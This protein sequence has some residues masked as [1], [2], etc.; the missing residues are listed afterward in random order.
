MQLLLQSFITPRGLLNKYNNRDLKVALTDTEKS[1]LEKLPKMTEFTI[2]LCY[3]ILRFEHLVPEPSSQWE[4]LPDED[5]REITDDIKRIVFDTNDV[6]NKLGEDILNTSYETFKVK[7]EGIVARFDSYLVQE[8]CTQCY[9]KVISLDTQLEICITELKKLREI[10][11]TGTTTPSLS[12]IEIQNGERFARIGWVIIDLFPKILR[13]VI[14]MKIAP[15]FFIIK[16]PTNKWGKPPSITDISTGDDVE[17]IRYL[18]N[19]FAHRSN[20]NVIQSEFDATFS[21]FKDICRRMD[22]YFNNDCASGHENDVSRK[23][24]TPMDNLLRQKYQRSLQ[25]LENIKSRF[26]E[27]PV[28]FYWGEAVELILKNLRQVYED[29][30][31]KRKGVTDAKLRFQIVVQ[32]IEDESAIS[33]LIDEEF[34]DE[35]NKGL[36]SIQLK[37]VSKG[38]IILHV[39]I[40]QEAVCSEETFR[41]ILVQFVNKVIQTG[42]LKLP[43]IGH[44]DVILVQ[45]D[46][47]ISLAHPVFI[48]TETGEETPETGSDVKQNIHD[49]KS[50]TPAIKRIL[51]D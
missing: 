42:H 9:E 32:N 21:T 40:C 8:S 22:V 20:I 35:I 5:H 2:E 43:T 51:V 27:P 25:E 46:G 3:K 44:V 24:T 45:E 18:R 7:V 6:L 49:S 29:E 30:I 19:N 48:K 50:L 41:L 1:I 4:I 33:R 37:Q 11:V 16:E 13:A 31:D 10:D 28:T 15:D 39:D 26:V 14:Q 17:R 23:E 36:T 38:S 12:D 34:K 47:E